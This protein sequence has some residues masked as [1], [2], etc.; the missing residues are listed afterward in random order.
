MKTWSVLLCLL[1]VSTGWGAGRFQPKS[2]P[3]RI[4]GGESEFF[5]HP[6]WSPDGQLIA[7]TG[8]KY[9]GIWLVRP[10]G[11]QL[12]QLTDEPGAGFG[13]EWSGDSQNIL[14]RVSRFDGKFR[15]HA[16]KIFDVSRQ[17]GQ[18]IT[19]YRRKM[20]SLPQWA[21]HDTKIC[22]TTGSRL[23]FF[24]SGKSQTAL[25]KSTPAA[26]L[27]LLQN[28]KPVLV[29]PEQSGVQPLPV[30]KDW[31]CLNL[32]LS[33]D[34]RKIAFEVLGDHLFVMHT[35]GTHLVDLGAGHRPQWAPD[36]E[37]LV[38]MIT[39]DDGHQYLASDLAIAKIDGSEKTVLSFSDDRL[40]QN[41][42][43][44]PDGKYLA[45][46]VPDEGAIYVVGIQ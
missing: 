36:S 39:E 15:N 45:F 42:A 5:M 32:V 21:A 35:D 8:N 4:A 11:S 41:P 29:R 26:P 22:L 44:S 20:P 43:W 27:C 7:I 38:F 23:E 3:K 34:G 17:T 19:D 25:Q 46:D 33:P 31:Q 40:E 16:I 14:T 2:Q 30:P 1:L 37:Y 6:G 10:D 9:Q 28:D 12:R 24:D 18:L 13:L